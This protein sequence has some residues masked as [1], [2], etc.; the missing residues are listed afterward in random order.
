MRSRNSEIWWLWATPR[1]MDSTRHNR[2]TAELHRWKNSCIGGT[3][4]WDNAKRNMVPQAREEQTCYSCLYPSMIMT[5]SRCN[6]WWCSFALLFWMYYV[7]LTW[8]NKIKDQPEEPFVLNLY[9]LRY[10]CTL[11]KLSAAYPI[12][13]TSASLWCSLPTKSRR[14]IPCAYLDST[15]GQDQGLFYGSYIVGGL[16]FSVWS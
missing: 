16:I 3:I 11:M 13:S 1:T 10:R 5:R 2:W 14:Y 9:Y 4:L 8:V 6:R 15:Y 7:Q 12:L